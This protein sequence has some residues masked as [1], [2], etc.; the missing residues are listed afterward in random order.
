MYTHRSTLEFKIRPIMGSSF[1]EEDIKR[2]QAIGNLVSKQ[3]WL[4]TWTP[5]DF[6]QPMQDDPRLEQF[7]RMK[8]VEKRWISVSPPPV[9]GANPSGASPLS[10]SGGNQSEANGVN[11]PLSAAAKLDHFSPFTSPHSSPKPTR[12]LF[13]EL[14]PPANPLKSSNARATTTF[15]HMQIPSSSSSTSTTDSNGM[16][17]NNNHFMDMLVKSASTPTTSSTPLNL[18]PQHHASNDFPVHLIDIPSNPFIAPMEPLVSLLDNEEQ[19]VLDIMNLKK[20]Y[21]LGMMDKEEFEHRRRQ[22]VDNMT[23][24]TSPLLLQQ[25]AQPVAQPAPQPA[26]QQQQQP[27]QQVPNVQPIPDQRLSGT[28]R[29]IRH[30]F[31]AKLGKW[32][33]TATI[34]I[35]EPTPFAEGAM[36]KAFRM[37]DLSAE[38]PTSQMVAKLFKDP[39]E[40]R[41]VYFKDVEMQTY[42]KEIAERFNAKGPPKKIDFVPA[43]VMEL[44]ERQGKPFCAVEYFIEG[45]YEKHNN[46]YGFKNDCDR[47]TPQA[48]SHFSYEDSGCQLI[49]VDIQGVGDVYTDPQIHSSDGQGFGK[50]NLGIEGIK[51]F[52]STHQCN[53]ICHYL[54]L[55]SVNPKPI[56]DESGTMPKPMG[57]QSYIRPSFVFP[58]NLQQSFTQLKQLKLKHKQLPII[59]HHKHLYHQCQ[60]NQSQR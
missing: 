54:G 40:D 60:K 7:L 45:K 56:T 27:Q 19:S 9:D 36:R 30:R 3:F 22:I 17:S 24:T 50:G 2:L 13:D 39:N 20:L 5:M 43:F 41:M 57:Q 53:S 4:A 12:S 11:I 33:Q 32:I 18:S 23:K 15:Q 37:K 44:V 14:V 42:A 59:N 49:V 25:P 26:P 38:G 52:F 55:S 16:S 8:Y 28:E 47:N 58:P 1:T 48:F 6:M 51:R 10:G 31:D 46:N 29:V 34:V 35:T 21:D